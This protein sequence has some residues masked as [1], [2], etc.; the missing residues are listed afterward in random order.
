MAERTVA[1]AQPDFVAVVAVELAADLNF[2]SA[3]NVGTGFA[4][5]A[6]AVLPAEASPVVRVADSA[7]AIVLALVANTLV[8]AAV[9]GV[10]VVGVDLAAN[11]DYA[12]VGQSVAPSDE[13]VEARVARCSVKEAVEAT[14]SDPAAMVAG[15]VEAG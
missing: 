14:A 12:L 15:A 9:V 10:P 3:V 4:M 11:K 2:A 13:A 5:V 1:A 6:S 7:P 8:P